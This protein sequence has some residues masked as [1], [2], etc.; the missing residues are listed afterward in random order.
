ML[1]VIVEQ[2]P[3]PA[4]PVA[5]PVIEAKFFAAGNVAARAKPHAIVQQVGLDAQVRSPRAVIEI[6]RATGGL[7]VAGVDIEP[8][9][10]ELKDVLA[11]KIDGAAS[12]ALS[13]ALVGEQIASIF[14]HVV[15]RQKGTKREEPMSLGGGYAVADL[16]RLLLGRKVTQPNWRTII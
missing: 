11:L 12:I 14:N 5:R 2:L 6:A 10:S 8:I 16:E 7:L 13:K 3:R 15:A 1:R 4:F 9:F